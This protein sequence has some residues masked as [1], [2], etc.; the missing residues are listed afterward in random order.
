MKNHQSFIKPTDNIKPTNNILQDNNKIQNVE[1][2]DR[3]SYQLKEITKLQS[4][5]KNKQIFPI[6]ALPCLISM[7]PLQGCGSIEMI[8]LLCPCQEFLMR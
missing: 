1:S 2:S 3:R 8:K 5:T 6:I 4:Q 7:E